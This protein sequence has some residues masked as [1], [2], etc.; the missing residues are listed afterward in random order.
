MSL[1]IK[2]L[3]YNLIRRDAYRN[4]ICLLLLIGGM[5]SFTAEAQSPKVGTIRGRLEGQGRED[6]AA[7]T[8]S[9]DGT[10]YHTL[11]DEQGNFELRDIP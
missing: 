3:I 5:L 6:L 8:I 2:V 1:S 4:I 7:I 9:L 10:S 11:T